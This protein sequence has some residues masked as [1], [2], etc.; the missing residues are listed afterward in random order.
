MHYPEVF[1]LIK[2]KYVDKEDQRDLYEHLAIQ[3]GSVLLLP[4]VN[5]TA[6]YSLNTSFGDQCV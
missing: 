4:H 6:G 3:S 5:G 1:W 2:L